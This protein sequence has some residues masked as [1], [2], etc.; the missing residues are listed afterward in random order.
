MVNDAPPPEELRTQNGQ[1]K[2]A[3]AS[4]TWPAG[5]RFATTDYKVSLIKDLAKLELAEGGEM[6]SHLME[7]DTLFERVENVGDNL[8]SNRRLGAFI[9]ANV[10]KSYRSEVNLVYPVNIF[11][12]EIY[13]CSALE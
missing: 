5:R 3:C 13:I 12:S 7:L 10:L 2:K 8:E 11:L 1:R 9:L 4:N 6:R